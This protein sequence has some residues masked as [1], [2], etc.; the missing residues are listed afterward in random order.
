LIDSQAKRILDPALDSIGR[1]LARRGLTADLMTLIGFALAV[2]AAIAIG[3]RFFIPGL[4]LILLSRVCDGLDGAIAR[5][6]KTTDFGGFLDIV[7]DF[8]FYGLIP[9]AFAIADPSRNAVP[10]CV[11]LLSFYVN[12]GSFLAFAVISE[13]RG[14][15]PEERGRK[16][17]LFTTGLTEAGETLVA[18]VAMCLFPSLFPLF[19]WFFAAA[20]IY[21]AAM[22]IFRARRMFS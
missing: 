19:A 12:G 18:F 8:G 13:K 6:T 9:L 2:A 3:L 17:F 4:F 21:T 15:A 7:L 20:V 5:A 16:S 14:L 1:F 22:R 10:A 11:L